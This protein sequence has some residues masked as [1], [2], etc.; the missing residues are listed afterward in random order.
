M[1][2]H[3]EQVLKLIPSA[4]LDVFPSIQGDSYKDF[5]THP[6][7]QRNMDSLMDMGYGTATSTMNMFYHLFLMKRHGEKIFVIEPDLALMLAHTDIRGITGDVLK[8]P[9]REQFFVLPE[10][11]DFMTLYDPKT[12]NHPIGGMYVAYEGEEFRMLVVGRPNENS[13]D[14]LDDTF[15]YFRYSFDGRDLKEQV[16]E[17]IE[18]NRKDSM[19]ALTGGSYNLD[20]AE[21]IFNFILN[22]LLYVTSTEADLYFEAWKDVAPKVARMSGK[23]RGRQIARLKASNRFLK[24]RMG[25]SV[26]L[27]PEQR[28]AYAAGRVLA[29]RTLVMGHWQHYWIGVGRTEQTLKWRQPFW[30]GHGELSNFPH[31]LVGVV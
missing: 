13:K 17:H 23:E 28:E 25:R 27:T 24:I 4:L 8:T 14:P 5:L 11:L 12:G 26:R 2:I 3:Y 16:R 22:V 19:I 31:K 7:M 21:R 9:Y 6:E 30:R 18:R 20:I 1:L 15:A 10:N 29:K